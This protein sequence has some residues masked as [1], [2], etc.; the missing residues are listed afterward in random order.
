MTNSDLTASAGARPPATPAGRPPATPPATP[1]GRAGKRERLVAAAAQMLHQQGAEAT[2]LADIA[3][4]AGVPLGNVYYYF[5]TKSDIIAAVIDAHAGAVHSMLAWL[6]ASQADPAAR[7]RALFAA[8]AGE[9]EM[10]ARYGC[11]HGTLCQELAKHAADPGAPDASVLVRIP[12]DWAERQFAAMGR[13]DARDLAI[14]A[15]AAYQGAALLTSALRDPAV[16]ERES[17]RMAAWIG[18]LS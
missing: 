5:K 12:V 6:D 10:V 1:A 13:A 8:L 16:L 14:Q 4:A 7:L 17:R 15:I 9:N 11:P 3:K 2:T 18:T